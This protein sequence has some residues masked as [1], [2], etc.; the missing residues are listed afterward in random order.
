MA[1]KLKKILKEYRIELIHAQNILTI[2]PSIIAGR[3]AKIPVIGTI[4]DYW[5]ICFRRSFTQPDGNVCEQC[6]F[7]NLVNG[8]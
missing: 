7:K 5:P 1:Q 2:P 8:S 6:N 3:K 4:R